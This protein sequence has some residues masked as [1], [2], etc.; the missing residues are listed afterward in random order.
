MT[1]LA[2]AGGSFI[3]IGILLVA[4]VGITFAYYSV[5]G[6]GI[7]QHGWSDRDRAFGTFPGKDPTV[8]VRTW[9]KGSA[10]S[11]HGRRRSTPLEQRTAEAIAD[12][13]GEHRDPTWRA[14]I[15]ENVQLEPP[16]DPTRD[17]VRGDEHADVVLVEYGEYSCRFCRDA[18]E[19]MKRIEQRADARV[20]RVFRHFPQTSVHPEARD[21]ALAA[22]AA[23][24]QG[25]F[26][27]MHDL[28]AA[29]KK[30]LT[31]ARLEDL[32]KRAGVM[33]TRFRSDLLDPALGA[34]VDEDLASGL[35]SGVN[36]TPTIYINNVRY[37]DD[38][39]VEELTRAIEIA[40]EVTADAD[41]DTPGR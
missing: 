8:D 1:V 27:E 30:P 31:S 40:R 18:E 35:R 26:W 25:R 36:G 22:E 7:D 28:L 39:N 33:V 24:R 29:N 14:R 21:A 16:V 19:A 10:S 6:S 4:L 38:T 23:G 17:W 34:R 41:G 32:A 12:A 5:K 37:D 11:Q 9:G 3:F 2:L 20:Q 15:G 13:A